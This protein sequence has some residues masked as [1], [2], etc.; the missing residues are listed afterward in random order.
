MFVQRGHAPMIVSLEQRAKEG[1]PEA[2]ERVVA[3]HREAVRKMAWV[4]NRGRGMVE[5]FE[6]EGLI[7]IMQAIAYNDPAKG[8]LGPLVGCFAGR[9]MMN[10][11][12]KLKR[13]SARELRVAEPEDRRIDAMSPDRVLGLIEDVTELMKPRKR[14]R[15]PVKHRMYQAAYL[16]RHREK[17]NARRRQRR[18]KNHDQDRALTSTH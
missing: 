14:V 8:P 16:V 5:D 2:I 15:D 6:S 1:D 4:K 12:R 13:L 17:I 3:M 10:M 9:R 18:K 11:G 7:G